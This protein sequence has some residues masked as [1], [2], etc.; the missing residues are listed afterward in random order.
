[1]KIKS[2][3]AKEV[4]VVPNVK[5]KVFEMTEIEALPTVAFT[6]NAVYEFT[7]VFAAVMVKSPFLAL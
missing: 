2:P 3:A 1:M 5:L 4:V 6:V 7:T